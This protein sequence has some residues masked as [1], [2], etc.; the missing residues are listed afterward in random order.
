MKIFLTGSSGILGTELL[1][2]A[3]QNNHTILHFN[4]SNID[5]SD[6]SQILDRVNNF[7]PDVIIHC[8]AMTN[9]DLCEDDHVA[10]LKI[11]VLGTQNLAIA[12]TRNNA[13]IVYI[14]SCGVYGNGKVTPYNELDSTNPINYH[15][16]TKLEGE[17]RI[18]EH[19]KDYL[20]VRTGWLFGGSKEHRKNF[21]EARRNEALKTA[22]L[23]SAIDKKGSPTYTLELANQIFF[24][25]NKQ[26]AGTFNI[27]NEG[28]ATRFDYVSE[29]IKLLGL[30]N[31]IKGVDSN[32]F[33]RKAN[34]PDNE[35]LENMNLNL[36]QINQMSDWRTALKSYITN[37]Y[38]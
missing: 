34:M 2:I 29:I 14:S 20:I 8:A 15:H 35:S 3:E 11:N 38:Y 18:K 10:A 22:V 16:F 33:P 13:K 36:H 23:N 17:K 25:L 30:N 4:S 21:V 27:V 31:E 12:S 32:L 6:F 26:Y 5:L 24:L 7:K 1:K 9:V 28:S 19:S 37:T